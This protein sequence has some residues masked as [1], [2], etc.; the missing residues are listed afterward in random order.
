M[1]RKVAIIIVLAMGAS[2]LCQAAL[3]KTVVTSQRAKRML[4]GK[5]WLTLQWISWQDFG[6]ARVVEK[7]GQLYLTGVQ[8]G[9]PGKGKNDY[10][11][12]KGLIERVDARRFVFRGVIVTRVY[13]INKGR[14]CVRRGRMVFAVT[15]RRK[16]WR[17]MQMKNPCDVATDYVDIFFRRQ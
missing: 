1:V 15:K 7:D 12:V 13:H 3:A 16:F 11:K 17:L 9:R 8:R 10:L 6:I 2:I 4:L 14:P 5:H